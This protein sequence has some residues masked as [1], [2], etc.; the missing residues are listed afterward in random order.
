MRRQQQ[1]VFVFLYF[2]IFIFASL[3]TIFF[4]SIAMWFTNRFAT[5]HINE[6]IN[7][8]FHCIIELTIKKSVTFNLCNLIQIQLLSI[9]YY[10]TKIRNWIQRIQLNSTKKSPFNAIQIPSILL[11]P[12]SKCS[13]VT[14]TITTTTTP[15]LILYFRKFPTSVV[16]VHVTHYQFWRIV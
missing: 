4:Y 8:L 13:L 3:F 5:V 11:I 1:A 6:H 14:S 7:V 9:N 16:D 12:F 2:F 10:C 15:S